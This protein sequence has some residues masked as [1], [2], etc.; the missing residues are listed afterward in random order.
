MKYIVVLADG[1]AD[2]PLEQL[3]GKTPLEAA[4]K[5]QIDELAAHSLCGMAKTIPDGLPAGSDTANLSVMGYA[6]NLYYSGRSPLEAV[7]MGIDLAPEDVTY[8]C[9]TVT[10]SDEQNIEDCTMVDYS[11]D[12]ISTEESTELI[13]FVNRQI[14]TEQ[15][16]LYPGVSYRHC[17]VLKNAADGA[18]TTPPHDIS[19]QGVRGHLPQGTNG[20]L[21][22]QMMERSRELLRDHPVN[23]KRIER[24]LNPANCCWFWGEGRKPSLKKFEEL[25]HKTGAVVSAVDLIK[26]IG[27]CAGL[28]SIDVAGATGNIHTN[29]RG[30]AQAGIDALL[31]DD[32]DFV[33]IHLEAPDECGHR[34]ETENK[35]RSIELIDEQV[36]RPV[37]EAMRQAGEDFSL[38]LMPDHPTP[39]STRTHARDAVPFLLYRS[40]R[41]EQGV[42][43]YCEQE[44]EKTGLMVE[45]GFSL[46]KML[47]ND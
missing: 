22:L 10:L 17:L 7:S 13:E 9:N 47:L 3:G 37:V 34:A 33:Y 8:R 18:E 14:Q 4:H 36:V 15:I 38:L 31:K 46:M 44:N 2:Y 28:D 42:P 39:I 45:Q 21:L 16:H 41:E 6:P 5:P 30:K 32:K 24:G 29:F 40:N 11:S 43:C 25:Y 20:E 27:L 19:G 23:Q 1:A 35:V 26:G 12:E